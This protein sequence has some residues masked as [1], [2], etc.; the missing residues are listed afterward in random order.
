MVLGSL[1]IPFG[2]IPKERERE[3]EGFIGEG[4]SQEVWYEIDRGKA[5]CKTESAE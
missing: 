3:R 1:E 2:A 4:E 5:W